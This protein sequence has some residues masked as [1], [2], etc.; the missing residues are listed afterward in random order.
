MVRQPAVA[1]RFYPGE[2]DQ[3]LQSI[4]EYLEPAAPSPHVKPIGIVVPHAGYIYSGHVAGAV[5]S[6]IDLPERNVVLCPNHTGLGTPLSIM[7]QGSWRTPLGDMQIEEEL[8]AALMNA[9]PDLEEDSAAHRFEHAIEVQVPFMQHIGGESVRFV[10]I[11]VGTGDFRDLESLG[12]TIAK[13]IQQTAP[14]TLVIASSDMNHYESDAI[15]RVK[16]RKAIDQI[17]A[18][19]PRGLYDVVRKEHISMCGYGPTVAMLTAAKILGATRAEL[20]KY[21]TSGDVS[22]D[23]D[24]VV[25]YAGIIVV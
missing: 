1:G 10:P 23:F 3:L 11:T 5:Y 12:Q 20:V 7:S 21:A 9:D 4:K 16:D 15:T 18:M 17:L 24:H 14:G 8:S 22:L 25:G 19:N 2:P 6:R 13:V